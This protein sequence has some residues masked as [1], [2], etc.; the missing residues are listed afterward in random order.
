MTNNNNLEEKLKPLFEYLQKEYTATKEQTMES[1][2]FLACSYLEKLDCIDSIVYMINKVYNTN[3]NLEETMKSLFEYLQEDYRDTEEYAME[4]GFLASSYLEKLNCINNTVDIINKL[5][6]TNY[7][8]KS[9]WKE[10]NNNNLEETLTP[11]F[12][13]LQTE[14]T[15]TEEDFMLSGMF[16]GGAREE[17]LVILEGI[18]NKINKLYNTNYVLK[19]EGK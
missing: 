8:L 13:H 19:K 12:E 4:S 17:T 1:S 3:K 18:V 16:S 11:L 10:T 5:Y 7:N 2:G 9:I 15:A 14:Y 6:N